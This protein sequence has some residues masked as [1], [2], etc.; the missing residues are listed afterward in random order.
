MHNVQLLVD[1]T[2]QEI[3]QSDRKLSYNKDLVVNLSHEKEEREVHLQ[4]EEQQID[5]LTQILKTI[6]MS[7]CVCVCVRLLNTC[8]VYTRLQAGAS[9]CFM[10]F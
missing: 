4:E 2:E 7:V 3:V 8:T 10:I 9:I 5:K 6:E 1:Q